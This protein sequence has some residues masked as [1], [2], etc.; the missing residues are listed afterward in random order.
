MIGWSGERGDEQLLTARIGAALER[1]EG[2]K[3]RVDASKHVAVRD[4]EH[5]SVERGIVDMKQPE[6][7][8]CRRVWSTIAPRL[9]AGQGVPFLPVSE[10]EG[11]E[12]EQSVVDVIDPA[13]WF[14]GFAR[15]I[16]IVHIDDVKITGP[17]QFSGVLLGNTGA[18][19]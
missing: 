2:Y 7:F 9:E 3:N 17:E 14:L 6:V 4:P 12:K 10:V 16:D 18:G 13:I 5:P 19:I 8:R 11:V 15:P 1:F